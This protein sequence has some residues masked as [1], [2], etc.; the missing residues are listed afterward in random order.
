MTT[1]SCVCDRFGVLCGGKQEAGFLARF[2]V[3]LQITYNRSRVPELVS[4][5]GK[6]SATVEDT[7][8]RSWPVR[9]PIPR[10]SI[11]SYNESLYF[12]KRFYLT[13]GRLLCVSFKT[14]LSLSLAMNSGQVG[15]VAFALIFII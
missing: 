6:D 12:I 4:R 8:H 5:D 1:F 2:A 13:L 15:L 11:F 14:N 3:Q 10:P 7:N 9:V